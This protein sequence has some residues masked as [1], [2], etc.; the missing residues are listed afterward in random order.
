[1]FPRESA[2]ADERPL[3]GESAAPAPDGLDGRL[4][5]HTGE[6]RKTAALAADPRVCLALASGVSFEQGGTPCAD[7][8]SY[9]SLLIWGRAQRLEAPELR[10]LALRAI[11]SKHDPGALDA[12]FDDAVLGR[13]VIYEVTIKTASYKE[14]P[15]PA[16]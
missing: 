15:R 7:G 5:F 8:F 9:R 14:Q 11:V 4:Y 13:T 6:G 1:L 12:P 2:P 16:G 10:E 3:S